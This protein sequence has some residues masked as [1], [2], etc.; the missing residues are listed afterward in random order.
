[1]HDDY[2]QLDCDPATLDPC[3]VCG[4]AA[5][6]WQYSTSETAPRKL[7]VMCSHGEYLPPDVFYRETVRD[8]I[9]F[10]GE[11]AR[12]LVALRTDGVSVVDGRHPSEGS[13]A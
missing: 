1:M 7:V 11:F 4:S 6:L 13:D 9:R 3:P 10:W 8:A 12:A 5:G 2:K